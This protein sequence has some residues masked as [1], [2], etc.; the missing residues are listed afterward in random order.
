MAAEVSDEPEKPTTASAPGLDLTAPIHELSEALRSGRVSSEEL[1]RTSLARIR[2]APAAFTQV[3]EE[4]AMVGA[5]VADIQ[6]AVGECR[7]RPLAGLP[8][9]VK[10]LFDV[11]GELTTSGS[12]KAL[13]E[14]MA[15]KDAVV[16][17]RL[18]L[19]GAV[20]VGKAHLSELAYTGLGYNPHYETPLSP[21][22]RLPGGSS[23]G[24]G[25]AVAAGQVWAA[26][27]T[28]T[29]G[30][31]RI[32]SAW[33]GVTGFKPTWGQVPLDGCQA[34]AESLDSA[35]PLANCVADC[36]VV[37]RVLAGSADPLAPLPH[38]EAQ[39]L[40]L[41]APTECLQDL[42]AEVAGAF[43]AA[44]AALRAAG[45]RVERA[46]VKLLPRV[47][48]LTGIVLAAE[49]AST[50]AKLLADSERAS[51]LDGA[52]KRRLGGGMEVGAVEY[53]C[54]RKELKECQAAIS[55]TTSRFDAMI[56]PTVP[57]LP[58]QLADVAASVEAALAASKPCSRITR[59]ANGLRRC[60][61]SLP[62]H[63]PPPA[64]SGEAASG[65]EQGAGAST[66]A[67]TATVLPVGLMVMG[68]TDGDEVCLGVAA[69]IEEVLRRAGLG[70]WRPP[71]ERLPLVTSGA[72][73][74]LGRGALPAKAAA[75]MLEGLMQKSGDLMPPPPPPMKRARL[76]E[77]PPPD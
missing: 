69:T 33:C 3:F 62:C 13:G 22:G 18:R 59:L 54:G 39:E 56:M 53:L 67:G 7:G 37:H 36:A 42:D 50:H 17:E 74:R 2:A 38:R 57:T 64:V 35:G 40:R 1:V 51:G 49:A 48:E 32:P 9:A 23:G 15:S 29:G 68:E 19:A 58:A 76:E 26:I 25:A 12:P 75:V 24:S 47:G 34:L 10:D 14:R 73:G 5:R 16:V 55:R 41:L 6:Q 28:D 30:S 31:I 66:A 77:R 21:F 71:V 11:A 70:L 4:V 63:G 43:E 46:S 52:V 8:V 44:V 61:V 20:L 65:G 27:G 72:L 45:A 60:A